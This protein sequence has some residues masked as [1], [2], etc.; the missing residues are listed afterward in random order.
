MAGILE[1]DCLFVKDQQNHACQ[2]EDIDVTGVA[3][4]DPAPHAP[5]PESL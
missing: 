2:A 4:R 3:A 1:R 5:K